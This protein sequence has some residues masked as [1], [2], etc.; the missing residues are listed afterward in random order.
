MAVYVPGAGHLLNL[1]GACRV[2]RCLEAV[3][4]FSVAL[5]LYVFSV[6]SPKRWKY[7][8]GRKGGI[9]EHLVLKSISKARWPRHA[10]SCKVNVKTFNSFLCYLEVISE[11]GEENGDTCNELN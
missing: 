1:V 6:A 2:D 11:D 8:L 9:C 10:V 4:Y 7:L 5:K 3:K